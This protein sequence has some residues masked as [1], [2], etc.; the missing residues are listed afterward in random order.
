MSLENL[1]D[2]LTDELRD[3]YNA[4]NQLTKALPKMAKAAN[5]EDLKNIFQEHLKQTEGHV[6]RLNEIFE[7]LG[8]NS[9]GRKCVA[10]QGIIEEAKDLMDEDA[11]DDVMDAGLICAAQKVEHYEMAGYGCARTWALALDRQDIVDLLQE[12]LDEEKQADEKL[13]ELAES[14]INEEAIHEES[15]EH[16]EE[17]EEEEAAA[18]SKTRMRSR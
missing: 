18:G 6:E 7:K 10:M 8:A 11:E 12:T 2:L 5:S 14:H 17:E 15:E 16:D 9:K 13:T 1:Q 4:E 3:L